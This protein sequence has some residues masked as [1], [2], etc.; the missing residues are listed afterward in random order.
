STLHPTS[1]ISLPYT[2]LFRSREQLR[3]KVRELAR[4]PVAGLRVQLR[5][6]ARRRVTV[7]YRAVFPHRERAYK[8]GLLHHVFRFASGN[9]QARSEEHTSELKSLRHIVCRH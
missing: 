5:R 9:R 1:S 4:S 8:T 2:T 7:E 3:V 6:V